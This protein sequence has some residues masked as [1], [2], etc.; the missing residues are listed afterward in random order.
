MAWGSRFYADNII[1]LQAEAADQLSDRMLLLDKQDAAAQERLKEANRLLREEPALRLELFSQREALDQAAEHVRATIAKG[2]RILEERRLL[3][4]E[5]AGAATK[6]RYRDMAFRMFRNEAL[7]KYRAQFDLAAR[8]VYLAA[9]AYDYEVNMV[10]KGNNSAQRFL[11]D[12]LRHRTLGQIRVDD[13]GVFPVAG[14][15]G[16]KLF[17][18]F[19][20]S[21][22]KTEPF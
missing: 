16:R 7:N 2:Q 12:I 5:V 15:M 19:T 21:A 14:R 4:T 10:G 3:R 8:Y 6:L 13:S 22:T 11:T 20:K 17:T 18:T 9:T 1:P